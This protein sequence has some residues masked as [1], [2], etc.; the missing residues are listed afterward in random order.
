MRRIKYSIFFLGLAFLITS[1]AKKEV[2]KGT[3]SY[4][5]EQPKQ[6]DKITVYYNPDSTNLAGIDS[7]T[8]E[9]YLYGVGIDNTIEYPMKKEN[10]IWTAEFSTTDSTRGVLIKFKHKEDVDNNNKKGYSIFIFKNG[11]PVPGAYAGLASAIN[12]WGSYYLDMDRD[13]ELADDYFK[14]D[15]KLHP[16]I[17][18]EYL[19]AFLSVNS[20]LNKSNSDSL[21]KMELQTLESQNPQSEKE[22]TLLANWYTKLK[23]PDKAEQYKKI[24]EEKYPNG[25]YAQRQLFNKFYTEKD[26]DKKLSLAKEYE[27]QFPKG[28]YL[29]TIYD[30]IANY[31]RDTKDYKKAVEFL[32]DN[33]EKP[34]TYRFYAV[35]SKMADENANLKDAL[36]IAEIGV[37]RSRNE[38][39]TPKGKKPKWESNKEWKNDREYILGLNLY[40]YGEVQTKLNN[41]EEALKALAEAVKLTNDEEGDLNE[42]YVQTLSKTGKTD[43]ILTIVPEFIKNGKDTP[44]MHDIL[45]K[46]YITKNGSDKGYDDFLA[47]FESAAKEK[48]VKDL[49]KE[50]VDNPAPDFSLTDLNGNKVSLSQLKGKTVV[51][52]FWATWCGPCKASFPGMQKAVQKYANNNNVKFLFVNAWENVPDKKKNAEDFIKK[53]KY[54]FQVLL[55]EQNKVIDSYKVSGIPTKFIIDKAGNIRFM[56]VGFSG[57]T[58]QMVDEISQMISMVN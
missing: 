41:D 2:I 46:A 36:H 15:F 57:N 4:N 12:T 9:A 53:N 31:Y 32:K 49:K 10:K 51:L 5:P 3:F 54:P 43:K 18:N 34:S 16:E 7:V 47:K 30:L 26:I 25:K 20:R 39:I 52:D 38:I 55:D 29:E 40:A 1:C 22:L 35:A 14:K 42:L 24:I 19:D 6:G 48:M 33:P 11:K 23:V 27:K 8:L 37:D 13:A 45:K 21:I 44:G 58:D 17:K 50:M 56:K 28:D